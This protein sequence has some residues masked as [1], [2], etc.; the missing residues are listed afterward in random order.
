MAEQSFQI[1]FDGYW[2]YQNKGGIPS[3]SGIYCVY[4]CAYN[5][6]TKTVSL[7]KLIYIG[8]ADN[9]QGRITNHEKYNDWEKLVCAGNELCFSFG[10][11]PATSRVRCEAAMIF[12]HKPPANTE[13]KDSFPFDKTTMNLS[14]EITLL[15]NFF[16]LKRT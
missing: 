4:E 14:G 6:Q 10:S 3:E 9:V 1:K 16:T 12:T 15:T 2:R 8:E 13:Y 7:K 5:A 11:V